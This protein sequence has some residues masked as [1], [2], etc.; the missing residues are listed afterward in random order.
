MSNK[1]NLILGVHNHLPNGTAVDEFES[2]YNRKIQPLVSA[3]YQFPRINMVFHYSG[4]M[5][6]W[7]ER[8][9]PE[10]FVLIDDLLSSRIDI[11]KKLAASVQN[12]LQGIL[13]AIILRANNGAAEARNSCI[14]RIKFVAC[15][16]RSKERF[17]QE[18]LFQF[19]GLNM[20][21]F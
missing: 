7:I 12:H 2:L 14:A 5:F 1:V 4:V 6:H 3:L 15:G 21:F 10:L 17:H 8:R 16:Y 19:G 9:H 11:L 18:I 20:A 13:N